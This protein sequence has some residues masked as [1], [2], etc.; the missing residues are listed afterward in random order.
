MSLSSPKGGFNTEVI[1][2]MMGWFGHRMD[3]PTTRCTLEEMI[4]EVGSRATRNKRIAIN[5]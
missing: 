5:Y 4:R 2:E 1:C 3:G